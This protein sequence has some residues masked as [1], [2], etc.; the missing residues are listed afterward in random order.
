MSCTWI[1]ELNLLIIVLFQM[2]QRKSHLK[3]TK[4]LDVSERQNFAYTYVSV[5][6]SENGE[7]KNDGDFIISTNFNQLR[8]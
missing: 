5:L 4:G 7:N 8:S 3:N 2:G 6:V 1:H